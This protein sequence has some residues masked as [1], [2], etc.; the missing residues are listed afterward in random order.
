MAP[1]ATGTQLTSAKTNARGRILPPAKLTSNLA[2]SNGIGNCSPTL[3]SINRKREAIPQVNGSD[4]MNCSAGL[5]RPGIHS[6]ETA[7]LTTTEPPSYFKSDEYIL[8]K[9][10]HSIPS[11]V[12][13][14][15]PT[16]FRFDNQEG[17]F[18]YQSPMRLMIEH[19]RL[20][21]IPHDLVEYFGDVPYYEDCMIVKI[22]DHKSTSLSDPVDRK[23][24]PEPKPIPF[25]I[26]NYSQY[27]TPSSYAPYPMKSPISKKP[28]TTIDKN[29]TKA[30]EEQD[31]DQKPTSLASKTAGPKKP[32]ILTVVLRPTPMSKFIDRAIQAINLVGTERVMNAQS[33][34]N[35]VTPN[36]P[37]TPTVAPNISANI[38]PI[39]VSS[40]NRGKARLKIDSSQICKI[41]AQITLATTAPLILK[42][43]SSALESATL[44]ESLAHPMY[45]EKPPAPKSR[46]RTVAEVAADEAFAAEQERYMLLFDE[47]L[48]SNALTTSGGVNTSGGETQ[49]GGTLFEA[50]FERF[51]LIESI[52]IQLEENKR[53]EKQKAIENEK[54]Q[55]LAET[56]RTRQ[57]LAIEQ[58]R[59]Q[60]A[61]QGNSNQIQP[62]HAHPQTTSSQNSIL[63]QAHRLHQQTS[64]AQA[65][66]PLIRTETPNSN[67]SPSI[68][69]AGSIPMQQSTSSMGGSPPRPGS[70]TQQNQAQKSVPTSHGMVS[71]KSQQS[72][73][74]TPRMPVSTP[75]QSTPASRNS[76]QT[77]RLSQ[78]SPQGQI[79][80]NPQVQMINGQPI[81]NNSAQAQAFQQ[82]RLQHILRQQ[83]QQQQAAQGLGV[84]MQGHQASPQQMLQAQQILR[85]QQQ[86]GM[87]QQAMQ[88]YTAQMTALAQRQASQGGIPQSMNPNFVGNVSGVGGMQQVPMNMQQ[89]QQLQQQQ[90]MLQAQAQQIAAQQQNNH[91]I[92]QQGGISQAAHNQIMGLA[93]RI[94]QTEK[95]SFASQ[96]PNV[97]ITDELDRQMRARAQNAAQQQFIQARRRQQMAAAQAA[98]QGGNQQNL[99]A[100]Q[101]QMGM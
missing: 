2:T 58:N 72:H 76:S 17:H 13:H 28:K 62:Q 36:L 6:D 5:L 90:M 100:L 26:H 96:N 1:S 35:G 78:R 101:H 25:S 16:H 37:L 85:N 46:K 19:L 44:I 3:R 53:I 95:T 43:V 41:E 68:N 57:I 92:Q 89:I 63:G 55:R 97:I 4:Q 66:S 71:Q 54:P 50:R 69:N 82:Q 94:Y 18:P 61:L 27:C 83:Q 45:N 48:S 30:S 59:S 34:A 11:L 52:R 79:S 75:V 70:A 84:I 88:A 49:S 9:Y 7:I 99:N 64:Q 31:N 87:P 86:Q 74:G 33:D 29:N 24:S 40:P 67:S 56:N 39:T 8:K 42:P 47:R 22:H 32:E 81:L 14:L 38:Q 10:R 12:V 77:P 91:P 73:S 60:Q 98:Q 65:T 21:T 93:H 20:R 51:K 23:E 80:H 15:H